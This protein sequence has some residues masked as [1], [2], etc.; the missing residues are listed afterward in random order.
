MLQLNGLSHRVGELEL[1]VQL[2]E[3]DVEGSRER[4]VVLR[5]PGLPVFNL[6]LD[7]FRVMVDLNRFGLKSKRSLV[8]ACC[9]FM[10]AALVGLHNP[11]V[12]FAL[13]IQRIQVQIPALPCFFLL[14]SLQDRTHL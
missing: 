11:E 1:G 13:L 4:V 3:G 10:S 2:D 6:Q 5:V 12:A 14:L 8:M 7:P 9:W